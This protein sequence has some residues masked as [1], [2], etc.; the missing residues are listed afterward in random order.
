MLSAINLKI[1]ADATAATA[2]M[3]SYVLPLM[4]TLCSLASLCT[5][6]FLVYGGFLYITSSGKPHRIAT[7]KKIIRN[8]LIGLIIVL[9]A[10]AL[11]A[12][13]SHAYSSGT[14]PTSS[15]LPGILPLESSPSSSSLVDVLI[16]A[17]VG[18]ILNITQTAATP[19]LK[20]L[21][22]FTSATPLMADNMQVFNL[23]LVVVAI[24]DVLFVVVVT[25]LG[26]HIMSSTALG[27]DEI[28]IKHMLPRLAFVFLLINVSIFGVDIII[29]LS[30][31]L[32]H[33]FQTGFP[34]TSIW[35]TL[36]N[37]ANQSAALSLSSLIILLVFLILTVILLVYYVGRLVTLYVGVVLSPI[38]LLL[39]LMPTFK[40]FAESAIKTYI[41]TIF[42]IFVHVV[43]LQ[44]AASIFDS[45]LLANP[46]TTLDPIMAMLVGIATLIALL[47]TQGVLSQLSLASVGPKAIRK[48]GTQ[49]TNGVSHLTT[50]AKSATDYASSRVLTMKEIK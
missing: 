8:A 29:G 32:I 17:V 10:S 47:K 7:A 22:Y 2:A 20:S 50:G 43:I 3:K 25:L 35:L 33:A 5:V 9:S 30:N 42:V 16:K 37:V 48:L 27:L 23:W 44:L 19:F 40:D 6:L 41:L 14:Q 13:L 24:A 36:T 39:W 11:T 31:A 38:V 46:N 18:L 21:S 4:A 1:L 15:N 26:F 34:S 49:F 12:I 45:M 28:D